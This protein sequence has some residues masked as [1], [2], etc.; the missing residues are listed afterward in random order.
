MKFYIPVLSFSDSKGV[1]LSEAEI[2]GIVGGLLFLLV[3]VLLA[4][5][6]II[7]LDTF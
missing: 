2:G 6:G 1:Y 4:I 5:I 3:A 7:C